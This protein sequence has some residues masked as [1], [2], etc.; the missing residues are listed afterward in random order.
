MKMK[1]ALTGVSTLQHQYTPQNASRAATPDGDESGR[2]TALLGS[3]AEGNMLPLM[4][5]L[6]CSCK[7]PT[8]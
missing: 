8:N 5:I 3:N 6:K 1:L 7:D 2:F 4:T